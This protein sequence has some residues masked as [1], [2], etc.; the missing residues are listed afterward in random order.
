MFINQSFYDWLIDKMIQTWLIN[1]SIYDLLIDKI[2]L[3]LINWLID[4]IFMIEWFKIYASI[5]KNLFNSIKK[6]KNRIKKSKNW[7]NKS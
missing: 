6:S 7:F 5:D 3:W 1:Q 4:S 2:V